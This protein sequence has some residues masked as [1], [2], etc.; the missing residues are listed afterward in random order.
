MM[1]KKRSGLGKG[2]DALIPQG[3][4]FESPLS[5]E[6]GVIELP[7][8]KITPNPRQPRLRFDSEELTGLAASIEEHGVI[9]P[10]IVSQGKTPG[11]YILIAGERR[12]LAAQK[13]GLTTVPV[14]IRETSEQGMVE[15]AL[16]ENLQRA[17][18]SP[19]ETAEAYRQLTEEFHLSHDAIGT[20]VGK[21]R[22]TITNTLRLL[23]LPP[24]V[25][26]ALTDLQIS[27][28]HARALLGLPTSQSQIAALQTILEKG[29][30]VRQT[31]E[32][33]RRLAGEKPTPT[34]KP[35]KSPEI[36]A[37][38]ER[39]RAQFGTKVTLKHGRKGGSITIHYY[40]DEE[41]DSLLG[42]FLA[43]D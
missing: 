30:N 33:T 13:A 20:R 38:E 35:E 28:G 37:L 32:L 21:S 7:L 12:L 10:L 43:E 16:I 27:E 40:S 6:R 42:H 14:I 36:K 2:L 15:L 11:D 34:P 39:L 41:L 1:P 25:K 8:N 19:L 4:G 26:Q 22:V 29:L 5:A 18:L 24:S 23:N 9:Q 31:E 3:G 17:D